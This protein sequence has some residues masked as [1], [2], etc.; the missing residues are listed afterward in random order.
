MVSP[1]S[2]VINDDDNRDDDDVDVDVDVDVDGGNLKA[3]SRN[4]SHPRC[5]RNHCVV[6]NLII[7][8][9]IT[10]SS[11]IAKTIATV[12]IIAKIAS[13]IL[14]ISLKGTALAPQDPR[15]QSC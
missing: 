4:I 7:I 6:G 9:I 1:H 2:P 12:F 11:L 5:L 10:I 3:D 14:C 8:S 13:T 15:R